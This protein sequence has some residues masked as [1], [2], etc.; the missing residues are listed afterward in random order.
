LARYPLTP[1]LTQEQIV[2]AESSIAR[3]Y[4]KVKFGDQESD[5]AYWQMQPY[6]VRLAALEQIRR[7]YHRWRYG[8]EPRLQRVYTVVKR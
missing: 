2:G 4:T 7:E 3:H 5:F 6:Q 1:L 8:A